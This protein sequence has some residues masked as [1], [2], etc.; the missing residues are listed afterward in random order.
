MSPCGSQNGRARPERTPIFATS[1]ST[2]RLCSQCWGW[3]QSSEAILPGSDATMTHASRPLPL[4]S[5][6]LV[7]REGELC[8][9]SAVRSRYAAYLDSVNQQQRW[10]ASRQR[11]ILRRTL[12]KLPNIHHV[13][14]TATSLTAEAF[15][16]WS[17]GKGDLYLDS[18]LFSKHP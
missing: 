18:T 14:V 12:P 2:I 6:D 16:E 17:T 10:T 1:A 11:D 8:V 5:I 13:V 9:D 7:W 4:S 15:N 3:S